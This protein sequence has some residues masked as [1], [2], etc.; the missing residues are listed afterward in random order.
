[1]KKFIGIL[2][3][4][5]F[6]VALS[7][8]GGGGIDGK[9][10]FSA[11]KTA[12]TGGASLNNVSAT[13]T[14]TTTSH[15][16]WAHVDGM[17]V[18]LLRVALDSDSNNEEEIW[19]GSN[20]ITLT[21]DGGNVELSASIPEGTYVGAKIELD[22]SYELKA[23]ACLGNG[24]NNY[25]I[26]YTTSSTIAKKANQSSCTAPTES[27]YGYY[28]YNFL[29]VSTAASPTDT[30]DTVQESGVAEFN[31]TISSDNTPNIQIIMDIYRLVTFWDGTPTSEND[32]VSPFNWTNNNGNTNSGFF[33]D[34]HYNF[35]VSYIPIFMSLD[36][37]GNTLGRIYVF[38]NDQSKVNNFDENNPDST[39]SYFVMATKSNG[40]YLGSRIVGFDDT[41]FDQFN[42]EYNKS[43]DI[44]SFYNGEHC[45]ENHPSACDS[46]NRFLRNLRITGFDMSKTAGQTFNITVTDTEYCHDTITEPDHPDWGNRMHCLSGGSP[47]TFYVKRIK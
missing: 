25:D 5:I 4:S 37:T 29:Y 22:G 11:L 43:G 10:T 16:T 19:S 47:Q 17:K 35:G 27:S 23:W 2:G 39:I 34:N 38:S 45:P 28:K 13:E 36:D 32:K 31:S 42:S 26:Y 41:V 7:S 20:T 6:V 14:G 15:F 30:S 24:I 9:L 3:I 1:M 18:K 44:A 33:P 12:G 8:C 40:D 46:T 21:P